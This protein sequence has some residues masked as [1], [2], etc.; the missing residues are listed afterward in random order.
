MLGKIYGNKAIKQTAMYK[1]YIRL[2]NGQEGVTNDPKRGR[3]TS[4][5]T[6]RQILKIMKHLDKYCRITT[7]EGAEKS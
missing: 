3:P 4:S 1:W 2:Q 6:S 7:R 5:I